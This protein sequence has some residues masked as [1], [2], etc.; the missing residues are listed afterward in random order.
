MISINRHKP[1]LRSPPMN[2]QLEPTLPRLRRK[3]D[4]SILKL[5]HDRGI[6][7]SNLHS[8]ETQKN[9]F[10]WG[11]EHMKGLM[12]ARKSGNERRK[13]PGKMNAQNSSHEQSKSLMN[14]QTS[15]L[16]RTKSLINARKSGHERP[17]VWTWTHE[18]SGE[19]TNVWRWT[20]EC[21]DKRTKG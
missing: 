14:A 7:C 1:E 6:V 5:T 16:E 20:H 10:N 2:A 17:Q 9:A 11:H 3:V 12:N 8:L 19:G 13:V 15:T 18:K 21:F 4:M